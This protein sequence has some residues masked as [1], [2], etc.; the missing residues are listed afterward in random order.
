MGIGLRST[1]KTLAKTTVPKKSQAALSLS[2][3][4]VPHASL[5]FVCVRQAATENDARGKRES[6]TGAVRK[7]WC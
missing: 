5:G 6:V 4:I 2:P 1:R 7:Q 3:D